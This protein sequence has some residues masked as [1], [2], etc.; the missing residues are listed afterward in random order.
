M[1]EERIAPLTKSPLDAFRGSGKKYRIHSCPA[2]A[3]GNNKPLDDKILQAFIAF[4]Q[5]NDNSEKKTGSSPGRVL[6]A[7]DTPGK[8]CG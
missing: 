5:C 3:L 1:E 7:E 8:G 2:C 4:S 6:P